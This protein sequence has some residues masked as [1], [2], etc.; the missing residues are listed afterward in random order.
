MAALEHTDMLVKASDLFPQA[1]L[2]QTIERV[3]QLAKQHGADASE[4]VI[5]QEKGYSVT[6]RSGDVETLEHHQEKSLLI[7][8]YKD[9]RSGSASTTDLSDSAVA[10]TVEKAY[11][12][13]L[14]AGEDP[15]AGLADPCFLAKEHPD[16]SLFHHWPL[17]PA[18]AIDMAIHCEQ[19]AREQD[20]RIVESENVSVSTYDGFRIYANSNHFIGAYPSSYHSIS[21]GL[22]A[23]DDDLMER[24]YEYSAAR[25]P[26]DLDDL[27]MVAKR[28]AE[29]T[30]M[31]LGARKIKTQHCPVI[32]H[33]PVAKGLLSAF[34]RAISGGNL[35]RK[36]SFLLDHLDK[37]IFPEHI[38]LHQQPHLLKGMG[39]AP[40]DNEGVKTEDRDY[41]RD[42]VLTSY[43]LGSYSARKL[44]LETTGNAGGIYNLFVSYSDHSL[45]KLFEEMGCGL[46]V[47]ELIGQGVNILT[48]NYSRG[49]VGYWIENGEIQ[50]PVHEVTIAGNLK[51]MFKDIV[52]VGNDVDH[53][54]NIHTGSIWLRQMTVAGE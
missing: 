20:Q 32:F 24:D 50:H 47:T 27:I 14:N 1:K 15:D 30:I 43:A 42:G 53:R 34:T 2:Q 39:S 17:T 4:A 46:F 52:A 19:V 44:D 45:K 16:L 40:F 22:V 38:H 54:G 29:K 33:A 26:K 41:V 23:K 8:I 10:K 49:V 9:K 6:A 36:S 13:A 3:L 25:D 37:T 18:E 35:Y 51:N 12:F 7:T 21:C 31:R 28:A 5:S 48:G 11:T